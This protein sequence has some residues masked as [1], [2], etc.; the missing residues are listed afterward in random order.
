MRRW[1]EMATWWLPREENDT[2]HAPRQAAEPADSRPEAP[3]EAPAPAEPPVADT[4]ASDDLTEIRGIGPAMQR[5]LTGLGI[6][7]RA[8]LAAADPET[9]TERLK[10]DR[11]VVSQAQVAAWIDSAGH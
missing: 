9:L 2:T 11:A 4:P 10:A 1:L 3:A 7:S 5:R 8:D 6:H